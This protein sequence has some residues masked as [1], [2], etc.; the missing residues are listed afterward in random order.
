MISHPVR[1]ER[2][3]CKR[4][5]YARRS[6]RCC[7]VEFRM[8]GHT[9]YLIWGSR[10]PSI[11]MEGGDVPELG[12]E[13]RNQLRVMAKG[14]QGLQEGSWFRIQEKGAGDTACAG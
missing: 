6:E 8:A 9:F 7:C 4:E 2:E 11:V 1:L 13:R 12:S 5:S 10:E 14:G 3:I